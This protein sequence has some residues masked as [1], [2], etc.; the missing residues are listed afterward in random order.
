MEQPCY[1]CGQAVEEGRPFCP[2]CAA[3]QIRVVLPEPVPT[4]GSFAEAIS[5]SKEHGDLP[6]SQTVPVL[7]LPMRWS[8]ALKPCAL[9]ALVASLL[10]R[11]GLNPFVAMFSA[12]F[13]AVVFYRQGRH[14]TNVRFRTEAA[15]GSIGGLLSFAMTAIFEVLLTL[16][17]HR[18]EQ[19]R[20]DLLSKMQQAAS[21]A[22]DPQVLAFLD[23]VKTPGGFQTFMLIS[24]IFAL[25]ASIVLGGLGGAVA[26]TIFK[27]RRP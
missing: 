14:E 18:S 2:H 11:L 4:A 24:I 15:F 17:A 12:G 13:L 3:P 20:A 19:V 6:A 7:A 9:A 1:K 8:Q 25:L 26:G 22:T 10:V 21:Q 23:W 5:T 27:R 16:V